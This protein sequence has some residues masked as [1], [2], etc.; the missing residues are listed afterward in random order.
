MY[1]YVSPVPSL[2]NRVRT[3]AGRTNSYLGQILPGVGLKVLGGPLRSD[4]ITWWL[5]ESKELRLRGWTPVLLAI[6]SGPRQNPSY[7]IV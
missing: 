3:G 2:P 7:L 1:A 6:R 4:G 5:V